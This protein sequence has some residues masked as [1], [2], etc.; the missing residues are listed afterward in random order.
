M[1]MPRTAGTRN[2]PSLLLRTTTAVRSCGCAENDGDREAEAAEILLPV[3]TVRHEAEADPWLLPWGGS[4]NVVAA[5]GL[6]LLDMV[7]RR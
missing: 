1:R 5:A 6:A 4:G 7:A 3:V 2:P